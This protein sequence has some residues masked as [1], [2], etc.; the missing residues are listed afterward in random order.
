MVP[1][2][3]KLHCGT[4]AAS[5]G[6]D[7]PVAFASQLHLV[8][9]D[10]FTGLTLVAQP[11]VELRIAIR[12]QIKERGI[13][14]PKSVQE[15]DVARI[16]D[17]A[18]G[19]F[20]YGEIETIKRFVFNG[21]FELVISRLQ[22]LERLVPAYRLVA[23]HNPNGAYILRIPNEGIENRPVGFLENGR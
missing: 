1:I 8:L 20:G 4:L 21:K 5:F 16:V 11:Y 12:F 6:D 10:L 17:I 18:V 2:G 3:L 23:A 22:R 19:H 7:F 13:I 14:V 9:R 15:I